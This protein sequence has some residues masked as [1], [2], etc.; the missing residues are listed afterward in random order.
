MNWIGFYNAL[1]DQGTTETRSKWLF[2]SVQ[3]ET[4]PVCFFRKVGGGG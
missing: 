2:K 1:Q 4:N 3:L